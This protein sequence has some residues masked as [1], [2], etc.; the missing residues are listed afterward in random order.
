M[1]LS[2]S[3]SSGELA[4]EPG[5]FPRAVCHDSRHHGT[6]ESGVDAG[7]EQGRPQSERRD[8]IAVGLG[9]SL[10]HPA[11]P[12][13]PQV[14]S[15]PACGA[16]VGHLPEYGELCAQVSI[17]G[18]QGRGALS[19]DFHGTI[20]LMHGFFAHRAIAAETFVFETSVGCKADRPQSGRLHSRLPRETA[21]VLL[22]VISVRT[23]TSRTSGTCLKYCGMRLFL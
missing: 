6:V 16:G 19:V 18:A 23:P 8:S 11:Q 7:K 20:Q 1:R 17:G 15:H 3:S 2:I 4:G 9:Y 5:A 21:R 12:E 10:D 13:A 14:V 22:M